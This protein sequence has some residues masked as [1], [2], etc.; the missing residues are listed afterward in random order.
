MRH[1]LQKAQISD[2]HVADVEPLEIGAVF[3]A[4]DVV[5]REIDLVVAPR[6]GDEILR[7]GAQ[8]IVSEIDLP[9]DADVLKFLIERVKLFVGEIRV[10]HIDLRELRELGKRGLERGHVGDGIVVEIDKLGVPLERLP[11]DRHRP[12]GGKIFV[13]FH[14]GKPVGYRRGAA[15]EIDRA[16]T[17]QQ[18]ERRG[19]LRERC[20]VLAGER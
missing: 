2:V 3:P 19:E 9:D 20:G 6:G 5:V 14:K 18:I 17:R 1:I 8:I 4:V 10:A 13:L 7:I 16:E 11:L 12:A 15:R